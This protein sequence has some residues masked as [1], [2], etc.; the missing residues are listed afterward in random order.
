MTNYE[1]AVELWKRE[2]IRT[3]AQLAEALSSYSIALHF[4]PGKLRTTLSPIMIQ[5]K[6][7][8]MTALPHTPVI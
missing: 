6:F 1:K 5:G 3:D 7:L 4:T 8:N 2:N